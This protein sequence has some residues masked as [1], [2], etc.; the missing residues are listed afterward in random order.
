LKN[1]FDFF[2]EFFEEFR[3]CMTFKANDVTVIWFFTGIER[4]VTFLR[5]NSWGIGK[6]E[7]NRDCEN[8]KQ[9]WNAPI[10]NGRTHSWWNDGTPGWSTGQRSVIHF[11]DGENLSSS[12][13]FPS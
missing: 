9:T 12:S 5:G 8:E 10:T 6:V 4:A 13:F 2:Q 1:F 7:Q 11:Q 3:S